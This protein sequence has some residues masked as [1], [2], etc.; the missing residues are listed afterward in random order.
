MSGSAAADPAVGEASPDESAPPASPDESAPPT[1]PDQGGNPGQSVPL[2]PGQISLP[3]PDIV[4]GGSST[5]TVTSSLAGSGVQ[6][7]GGMDLASY[8]WAS[9]WV[10]SGLM[11]ATVE[12]TVNPAAGASFSTE[13]VGSGA[14]YATKKLRIQR[15]PGSDALQA[16]STGGLVTC[17]ML[18]SGQATDVTLSFDAVAHT[19]D[20]LIAGAPSACTDLPTRLQ[21]PIEGIRLIDQANQ[22]YGGRVNFTNVALF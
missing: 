17:G 20:V 10:D 12:L 7:D 18:A 1:A 16:L 13:L 5:V 21:G 6:L 22:G 11:S 19:F 9:Y 2:E 3:A 14:S 15:I 8:A 4:T